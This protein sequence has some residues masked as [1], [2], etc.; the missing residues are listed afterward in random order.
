MDLSPTFLSMLGVEVPA[1]MT[2]IDQSD[3]W[4][5]LKQSCRD[6]VIVENR[7]EPTT[8]HV[9]TYVE[10]RY[11]ITV[12]YNREYGEIFDLKTDLSEIDNLWDKPEHSELKAKLIKR[13][14]FAEMGKEPLRMPRIA[15]A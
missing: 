5:G 15:G 8:I 6:S 3:T 11:K 13:L 9:K 2:G 14:L 1:S 4:R 7:H 10:D 12:Y